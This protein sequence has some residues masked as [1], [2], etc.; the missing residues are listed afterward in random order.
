MRATSINAEE[1]EVIADSL[2]NDRAMPVD[3]F[4][5]AQDSDVNHSVVFPHPPSDLVGNGM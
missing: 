2:G 1:S 3:V 4:V 5:E